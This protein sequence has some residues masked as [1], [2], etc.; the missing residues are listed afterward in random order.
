MKN[1]KLLLIL[2]VLVVI[3]SGC[4][5][6]NDPR[7]VEILQS[8]IEKSESLSS[9]TS[10]YDLDMFMNMDIGQGPLS[11]MGLQGNIDAWKKG[12]RTK[13]RGNFSL[14]YLDQLTQMSMYMY[15]LPGGFYLCVE[16]KCSQTLETGLPVNIETSE[17]TLA[18]MQE[19]LAQGAVTVSYLG[20]KTIIGQTCD[21]IR[22]DMDPSKIAE[23]MNM[24]TDSV[25]ELQNMDMYYI[26]CLEPE[27][28]QMLESKMILSGQ[29]SVGQVTADVDFEMSMVATALVVNADIPDSEFVLP[30][31]TVSI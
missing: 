19:L 6:E 9:Y 5:S 21:N 8:A 22:I 10:S 27:Y 16:E 2:P 24:P 12:D 31:S 30:Y 15:D 28:G 3:V 29:M 14:V 18:M 25:G 1:L 7:A 23:A 26:I 20:T 13:T 11:L 4:V 17:Q